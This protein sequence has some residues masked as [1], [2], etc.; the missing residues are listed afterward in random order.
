MFNKGFTLVEILVVMILMIL[1]LSLVFINYKETRQKIN[2]NI[3]IHKLA[4]DIRKVQEMAMAAEEFDG[5]VPEGGYGV[6]LEQSNPDQYILF[7]DQDS[8]DPNDPNQ[9]YDDDNNEEIETIIFE[10]RIVICSDGLQT[11]AG[12]QEY[13]VRTEINLVFKPPDP[14]VY[15][16]AD[17]ESGDEVR[18]T[19]CLT[20]NEEN[21][22]V[23][24]VNSSGLIIIE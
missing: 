12:Q 14:I 6:Y 24:M 21:K 1:L 19:F 8:L 16:N 5:A 10:N 11:K 17:N 20:N 15:I 18:I 13:G 3:A 22:E 23:I 9:E 4:Q 7:A 2:L